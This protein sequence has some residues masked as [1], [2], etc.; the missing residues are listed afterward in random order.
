MFCPYCQAETE[1]LGTA[2]FAMIDVGRAICDYCGEGF[3]I[4]YNVQ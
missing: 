1:V 2:E 4:I 3:L